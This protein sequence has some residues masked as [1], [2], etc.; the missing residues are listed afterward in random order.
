MIKDSKFFPF[1]K[2]GDYLISSLNILDK[3]ILTVILIYISFN[4][5]FM[6]PFFNELF[7]L[8]QKEIISFLIA[9][10]I[11]GIGL[12]KVFK[13][14]KSAVV[15]FL[16]LLFTLIGMIIR[17]F[18][19]YGEFSN[20]INFTSLNIFLYIIIV[21]TYCTIIYWLKLKVN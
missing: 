8:E 7:P 18:I 10:G 14:N 15:F 3:S 16:T 12:S 2:G 17:Y 20:T 1:I 9:Y 13:T 6:F 21:P 4:G 5:C 11:I 19:E